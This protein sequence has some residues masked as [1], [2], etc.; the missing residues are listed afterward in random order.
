V[1]GRLGLGSEERFLVAMR[2]AAPSAASSHLARGATP[3][4]AMGEAPLLGDARGREG[5]LELVYHALAVAAPG[6]GDVATD[7]RVAVARDAALAAWP[8]HREWGARTGRPQLGYTP[9][10]HPSMPE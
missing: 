5:S 1:A 7:A 8:L 4:R 6:V 9:G 3:L 10:L 2:E